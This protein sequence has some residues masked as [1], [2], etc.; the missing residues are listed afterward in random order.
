MKANKIKIFLFLGM[1]IILSSIFGKILGGNILMLILFALTLFISVFYYYF[2][3][4][5]I[6]KIYKV[7]PLPYHKFPEIH[8]IV[9]EVSEIAGIKKPEIY[10]FPSLHPNIFST[11]RAP[12]KG[13]I[14][15]TYGILKRL[16]LRELKAVV[17]HEISHIKNMDSLIQIFSAAFVSTITSIANIFKYLVTFGME[18]EN[19]RGDLLYYFILGMFSPFASLLI[20]LLIS[21]NREYIVDEIASKLTNDPLALA[22]ALEK[23]EFMIKRFPLEINPATSHIFILNPLKSGNFIFNLFNTHPDVEERIEKLKKLSY[24]I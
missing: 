12:Q 9:K 14:V 8:H 6:F 1:L 2:S 16:N 13:A 20:H 15:F 7:K 22:S 4:K 5:I 11:G 19:K 21:K 10:V 3:D 23:L 18:T 24:V 17:A